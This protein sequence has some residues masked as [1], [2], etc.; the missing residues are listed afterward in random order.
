MN[1][2]KAYNI[3]M[4]TF[5]VCYVVGACYKVGKDEYDRRQ[6]DAAQNWRLEVTARLRKMV[7][8]SIEKKISSE[9]FIV[10]LNAAK[11]VVSFQADDALPGNIYRV[12]EVRKLQDYID[13][14]ASG[15][16]VVSTL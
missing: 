6:Q 13:G 4:C 3:A 7:L 5:G 14:I 12:F 16:I 15:A 10:M 8:D 11:N 9:E 2:K 1:F